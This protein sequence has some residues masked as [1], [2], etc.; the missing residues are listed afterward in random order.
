M[1]FPSIIG[2]VYCK[3]K[4]CLVLFI[5]LVVSILPF[6]K[7]VFHIP[8][9]YKIY[10][11]T[12]RKRMDQQQINQ[13]FSYFMITICGSSICTAFF[14]LFF[15]PF[16]WKSSLMTFVM[17][18]VHNKCICSIHKHKYFIYEFDFLFIWN[19][20]TIFGELTWRIRLFFFFG[21]FTMF[22]YLLIS[23]SFYFLLYWSAIRHGWKTFF[24]FFFSKIQ[25]SRNTIHIINIEYTL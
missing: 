11:Y 9:I 13:G 10:I 2:F 8:S 12:D 15:L 18:S 3:R 7:F 17:F 25:K 19:E 24:L 1:L 21:N 4:R 6:E 20:Q 5:L 23:F 22:Q 16:G 14:L